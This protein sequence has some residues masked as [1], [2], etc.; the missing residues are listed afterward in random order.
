MGG[1][2]ASHACSSKSYRQ[3]ASC[4]FGVPK[5]GQLAAGP[6]AYRNFSTDAAAMN[7]PI[8]ES[9]RQPAYLHTLLNPV[10]I[11]GLAMGMVALVIGLLMKARSAQ[12]LAL[13]LIFVSAV[14]AWPVYFFGQR[15][16]PRVYVIADSDGQTYLDQHRQRAEKL[17]Y[18]FYVL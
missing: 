2:H 12:V 13:W 3:G 11:Y 17:I 5:I 18:A 8:I 4:D 14:S 9:I 7:D 15:A 10:P 6:R 16:Y 1:H